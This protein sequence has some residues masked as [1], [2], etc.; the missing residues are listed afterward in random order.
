[1]ICWWQSTWL[2][3]QISRGWWVAGSLRDIDLGIKLIQLICGA[4]RR[5]RLDKGESLGLSIRYLTPAEAI[6]QQV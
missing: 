6:A 5:G 3:I 2:G 1:M 4:T